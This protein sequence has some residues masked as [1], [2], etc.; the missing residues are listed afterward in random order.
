VARALAVGPEVL[1]AD[2][3][4]SALD[5]SVQAQLLNLFLDLRDELGVAIVFVAHQLA[6]I[7]EV[8][9]R[10]AIMHRGRM[11]EIGDAGVV[12]RDPQHEYTRALLDAHP[13]PDP[14]GRATVA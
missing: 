3:A 10:V 9:D 13:H 14:R 5:V 4:V 11:V 1:I 7:A 2:E 12:L 6:V 8:A